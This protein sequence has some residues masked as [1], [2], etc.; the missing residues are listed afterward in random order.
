M[1][2]TNINELLGNK[3]IRIVLAMLFYVFILNIV[4]QIGIFLGI[5]KNI[6]DMYFLW[7]GIV[8]LFITILPIKRSNL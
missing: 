6:L 1:D 5:N 7:I 8:I 2:F 4:Y 3:F